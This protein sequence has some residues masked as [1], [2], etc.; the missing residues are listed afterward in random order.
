LFIDWLNVRVFLQVALIYLC[1]HVITVAGCI[2]LS[3]I[4]VNPINVS[5]PSKDFMRRE[6][7]V[8][9]ESGVPRPFR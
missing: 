5:T 2:G 8:A 9:S 1:L 7:P 6:Q 3:L 4:E